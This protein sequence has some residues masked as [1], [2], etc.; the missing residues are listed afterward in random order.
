[1]MVRDEHVADEL[2]QD[3]IIRMLKGDFSGA[4]PNRGRFR[5]LLKAS[6]RN[7]VRNYW[8]R[9][10]RRSASSLDYEVAEGLEESE[11]DS[12]DHWMKQWRS[13][14]LELAWAEIEHVELGESNRFPYSTLRIKV[15]NPDTNSTELANLL[16]KK[17]G[18]EVTA[19]SFRQKL[20]RARKL[21]F[22]KLIDE[23]RDGLD[24]PSSERVHDELIV[25][26]LYSW[27]KNYLGDMAN[28]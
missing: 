4:D 20:K 21:F 18:Q 25:L 12:D 10:N 3:A 2:A 8:K 19:D 11:T 9:S 14:L 17:I 24:E 26:G 5:D 13:H 23:V 16:S 15:D 22:E 28:G 6:L 27:L 7:M 1:M